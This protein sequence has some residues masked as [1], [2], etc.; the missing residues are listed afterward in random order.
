[1]NFSITNNHFFFEM[2]WRNTLVHCS[3]EVVFM[4][5]NMTSTHL[6]IVLFHNKLITWLPFVFESLHHHDQPFHDPCDLPPAFL[7]H[8]TGVGGDDE[9]TTIVT[10]IMYR[11]QCRRCPLFITPLL[12][13]SDGGSGSVRLHLLPDP[14]PACL[15]GT[16]RVVQRPF[17][18][19]SP[20]HEAQSS[21]DVW[22][23]V[24][25]GLCQ[26]SLPIPELVPAHSTG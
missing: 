1:M 10:S 14:A 18:F 6:V 7:S 9:R 15:S 8:L 13:G 20:E 5:P 11:L 4:I 21:G 3:C 23:R 25:H 22:H 19:Y 2:N 17:G 24:R 12:E 16:G 26:D